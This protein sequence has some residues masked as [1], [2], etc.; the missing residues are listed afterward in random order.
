MV[1]DDRY[2]VISDLQ[3]PF[4]HE[5]A[6]SFCTYLKNHMSVPDANVYCV[7]DELDQYWG[8]LWKKD[9]DAS[10]TAN[11]EIQLSVEK[12][13]HWYDAFP[14][15]KLATSNHGSRWQ[16]KVFESEIPSQ[17]LR[18]YRDVIAA[19]PGWQW[20]KHWRVDSAHPFIVEHG[21]DYG[22]QHPHA[23]AVLHNGCSTVMGHHHSIF[24]LE[25]L[26]TN[27]LSCWGATIGCLI[28]FEAFAF[29]YAKNAKKKPILGAMVVLDGGQ[30]PI[31]VPMEIS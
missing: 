29:E 5:K 25:H 12:L 19:P 31:A 8:S 23:A 18:Q 26:K 11:Q 17:L 1:K 24:A 20:K 14:E 28:D 9:P 15:M 30:F 10:L 22:G 21:D 4:E 27:G 13:K 7:G 16:R 2:L 6:L 3:I